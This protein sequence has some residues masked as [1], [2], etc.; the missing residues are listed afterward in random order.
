MKNTAKNDLI[1]KKIFCVDNII[2]RIPTVGFI[3]GDDNGI[4]QEKQF[5]NE[6]GLFLRTPADMISELDDI[7][8]D[9]EKIS[10][11]ELFVL[12]LMMFKASTEE[13]YNCLLFDNINLLDYELADN[14][15]LFNGGKVR[16]N[17]E[18]YEKISEIICQI[19][20]REKTK[21]PHFG[22]S[23][24]KKKKIEYD[25]ERKKNAKKNDGITSVLSSLKLRLVCSGK[26]PY[27][28]DTVKNLT[29]YELLMS[30][31]QIDKEKS[32]DELKQTALVGNDLT[33]VSSELL[34][35]YAL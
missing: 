1:G 11:Y 12:M 32:A 19:L 8:I 35:P 20:C 17:A 23:F 31:K 30:I 15:I 4:S 21:T 14:E 7:G 9:F 28:F 16:I 26:T 18:N 25:R 2:I 10:E 29:I 6:A 3:C 27:S 5:W 33:K 22:N 34:S 13:H 24:A